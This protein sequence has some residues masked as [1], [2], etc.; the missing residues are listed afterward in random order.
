MRELK[1]DQV[2]F[3]DPGQLVPAVVQDDKTGKIL[4]LGYM[5]SE[6]IQKTFEIGKVTFYSR[7][8]QRLWIKGEESGNFLF[9]EGMFL[10][11]DGDAILV[12]A[13]PRGPT[14][15]TG[16]DTCWQEENKSGNHSFLRELENIIADRYENRDDASYTASLFDK[17]INKIAQK[18]GEEA[19]EL[20]IES[21]DDNIHLFKG[22]AADLLFHYLVLLRAKGIDLDEII[23]VLIERHKS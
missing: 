14:C 20:V 22:E 17:G 10:D 2:K 3:L 12:K 16:D 19:V 11:C 18:V 15:H 13:I 9:M 21:K 4:M 6:A 1:L 5:N 23:E 8:K 7:S